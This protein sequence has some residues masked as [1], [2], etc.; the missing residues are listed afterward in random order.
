MARGKVIQWNGQTGF[1]SDQ[2]DSARVFFGDRNLR[3]LSSS[4]IRVGLELEFDRGQSERGPR[5][6]NIRP[7]GA[8]IGNASGNQNSGNPSRREEPQSRV[9]IRSESPATW[10]LPHVTQTLIRGVRLEDRHPGIQLDRLSLP[11]DQKLQLIALNQF[12]CTTGDRNCFSEV[13]N[14]RSKLLQT[15]SPNETWTQKSSGPLTLHLSRSNAL[16]NAGLALHPVYGFAYLPGSGLKGM[17][18]AIAET[19]LGLGQKQI[20]EIFGSDVDNRKS[21]DQR[22]G[23]VCFHDAWPVA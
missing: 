3:G 8:S 19:E 5:A 11:G 20:I 10:I 15:V 7:I 18:R 21:E 17:A 4:D 1:L 2:N 13:A 14:R 22:A 6:N 16:E 9:D 12:A 23:N